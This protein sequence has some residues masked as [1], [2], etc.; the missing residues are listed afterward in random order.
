MRNGLI[1]IVSGPS[2][3]GKDTV[4]NAW[5][6]RNPLVERVVTFTTREPRKGE[7]DGVD[8]H[9]VDEVTFL[10]KAKAG[11][12]LEHKEV[13]GNRY[14]TPI[15]G[16]AA[17]TSSGKI[18]VLKIDV[19]GALAAM[20]KLE[21][22][23]SIFIQPPSMEELERRLL[24]RNTEPMSQIRVRIENARKEMAAATHYSASVVNDTVERAVDEIE[25]I[26]ASRK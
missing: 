26:V 23:V 15:D 17:I 20:P 2:G 6:E 14:G 10:K 3:A 8:Y 1:V 21:G 11:D 9:F 12:F 18:A 13:H 7:V 25:D 16:L 5:K 24:L 19:Q 4:I 22:E